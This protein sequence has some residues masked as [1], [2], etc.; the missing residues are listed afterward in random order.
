MES[1]YFVFNPEG[2]TPKHGHPTFESAEREALR[3]AEKEKDKIFFVCRVIQSVKYAKNPI[4][5]KQ[6]SAKKA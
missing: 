4:V 5:R 1:L 3:L 6:Y 2:E